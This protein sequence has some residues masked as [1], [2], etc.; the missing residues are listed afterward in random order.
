MGFL[1]RFLV[2]LI[3]IAVLGVISYFWPIFTGEAVNSQ[4]SIN[5]SKETGIVIKVLDGDTIVMS[6]S[7]HIRLLGINTPEK[8]KPYSNEA[9]VF[10][11][12]EILNKSV[13]LT[14]DFTSFDKYGRKLRYVTYNKRILNI[15]ILERGLATSYMLDSL[16]YQD[17]LKVAEEFAKTNS[18]G[19]WKK[20]A[21]LCVNCIS[22]V[23]L[24]PLEEY[25]ILLNE[26]SYNCN[27][28]GWLVKDDSNHFFKLSSLS[29]GESKKYPSEGIWNDNSDRF[30]MRDLKGDLVLF[31]EYS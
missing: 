6:N 28:T 8:G 17:K 14:P 3:I 22:L 18:N 27:L 21:D 20:S 19:L 4:I 1:K 7:D 25:F 24:D 31:Y 5:S 11:E 12:N 30:F 15:E 9:K 29:P 10:L 26:C 16:K 23:K 13:D 2:F